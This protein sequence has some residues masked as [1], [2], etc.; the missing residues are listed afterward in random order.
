MNG[1]NSI[2]KHR[3]RHSFPSQISSTY[4]KIHPSNHHFSIV[5]NI[6]SK[7]DSL[8]QQPWKQ[9]RL[10]TRPNLYQVL[11]LQMY[12]LSSSLCCSST[13]LIYICKYYYPNG[14][15]LTAGIIFPFKCV[16]H[17]ANYS[18]VATNFP[19]QLMYSDCLFKSCFLSTS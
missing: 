18:S 1:V 5:A 4:S 8:D 9:D 7:W 14:P 12:H 2:S 11:M 10:S 17:F 6:N 19:V 3:W 15:F 16:C 13:F